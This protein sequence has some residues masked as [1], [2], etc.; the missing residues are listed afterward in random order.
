MG[1]IKMG[2]Q[3]HMPLAVISGIIIVMIVGALCYTF[4]SSNKKEDTNILLPLGTV[5]Y[6]KTGTVPL[7]IVSR[8]ALSY[9]NNELGYLDYSA[10]LYPEGLQDYEHMIFFNKEDVGRVI[11]KGPINSGERFIAKNYDKLIAKSGLHKIKVNP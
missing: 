10:V 1:N 7:M 2:L 3:K 6:T 11:F 9:E 4:T 5:V 8:G